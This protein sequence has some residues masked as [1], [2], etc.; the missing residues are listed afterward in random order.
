[1][2]TVWRNGRKAGENCEI[3]RWQG[4]KNKTKS[5]PH[6][7]KKR[8]T[9]QIR[10][11]PADLESQTAAVETG[12][13]HGAVLLHEL[14]AQLPVLQR[15]EL[16]V[17]VVVEQPLGEVQQGAQ[18]AQS[19]AVRLHLGG[20]VVRPEKGTVVVGGNVP[21][22]VNDVQKARLQDLEDRETRRNNGRL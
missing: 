3:H 5:E 11:L 1:M 10:F 2:T 19:A 7:G 14:A 9:V 12:L 22:L 16:A 6:I 4:S 8:V 17:V 15:V 13:V 21:S 20:V 18:L